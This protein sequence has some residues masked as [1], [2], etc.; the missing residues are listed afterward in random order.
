MESITQSVI[1]PTSFAQLL[2]SPAASMPFA[3]LLP[4]L[5]WSISQRPLSIILSNNVKNTCRKN[6]L[7]RVLNQLI[8]KRGL[9]TPFSCGPASSS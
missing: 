8:L 6:H 1:E 4:L 3:S 9:A 2:V 7:T 5:S